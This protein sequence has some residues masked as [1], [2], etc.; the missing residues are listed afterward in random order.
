MNKVVFFLAMVIL[1]F[2]VDSCKKPKREPEINYVQKMEGDHYWHGTVVNLSDPSDPVDTFSFSAPIQVLNDTTIFFPRGGTMKRLVK[3]EKN[4]RLVFTSKDELTPK[5]LSYDTITY[6]Y[7]S[8]V[9]Y[10]DNG[11]FGAG[12]GQAIHLRTP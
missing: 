2:G 3:D 11:S 1:N 8:G 7:S 12:H 5:S 6:E 10:Y 9:I 4:K